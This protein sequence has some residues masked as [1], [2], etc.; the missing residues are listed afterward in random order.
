MDH[1]RHSVE[2]TADPASASSDGVPGVTWQ[3]GVAWVA[4][5]RHGGK[6][7]Y[8][9][10]FVEKQD[11]IA[12]MR[13]AREAA[14]EGRLAPHLAELRALAQRGTSATAGVSWDLFI[15]NDNFEQFRVGTN[16]VYYSTGYK[17]AKITWNYSN[18]V[19]EETVLTLTVAAS[20][21]KTVMSA[22]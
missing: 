1:S 3:H 13:A 14:T 10:S 9:G 22:F 12:A 6:I 11:A 18:R 4:Q 21:P 8:V 17:V 19:A 20:V 7:Q 2:Q 15:D 16:C 5:F